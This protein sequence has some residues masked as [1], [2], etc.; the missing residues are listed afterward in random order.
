MLKSLGGTLFDWRRRKFGRWIIQN[1]QPT[2]A[3]SPYTYYLPQPDFLATLTVGDIVKLVFEGIPIS[4]KYGAERMWVIITDR[5]GDDFVGT[6][7]NNP[8]DMPQL[9]SGESIIFNVSDIIDIDWTEEDLQT[10]GLVK[11]KKRSYWERCMVDSCVVNNGIPVGYIYR[12]A[13]DMGQDDDKY[14]DSG[15]RIRGDTNLMTP[16]QIENESA[17][18]IAI[19]VVLNADDSWLHLIDEPIGSQFSKNP[20]TNEF[21]ADTSD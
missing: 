15:W 9:K 11:H 14:P 2:A 21:E 17:K 20:E 6:L 5:K 8:F 3:A 16:E 4:K 10:R 19:G 12:E 7:D 18:Y 13:G 1:P